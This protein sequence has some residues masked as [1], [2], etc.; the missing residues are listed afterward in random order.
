MTLLNINSSHSLGDGP[1]NGQNFGLLQ[2]VV[3]PIDHLTAFFHLRNI[4][5]TEYSY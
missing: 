5:Y 3:L 2:K 4:S 1:L